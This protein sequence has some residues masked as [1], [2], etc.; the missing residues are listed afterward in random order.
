MAGCPIGIRFKDRF[1]RCI[2]ELNARD[3]FLCAWVFWY[4]NSLLLFWFY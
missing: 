4:K 1:K 2:R 3:L